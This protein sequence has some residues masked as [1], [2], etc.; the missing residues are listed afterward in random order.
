M[1]NKTIKRGWLACFTIFFLAAPTM[2]DAALAAPDTTS[3]AQNLFDQASFYLEFQYFGPSTANLKS[4]IQKYQ[5]ELEAACATTKDTCA[6][7]IAEP[8]LKTMFE[9]LEDG[10]AYYFPAQELQRYTQ[11]RATGESLTPKPALGLSSLEFRDDADVLQ[12]PDRLVIEVTAGSPAEKIGLQ[13]GDRWIG[14]N[15]VLFSSFGDEKTPDGKHAQFLKEFS[16]RVQA[17]EQVTMEI[18]RGKT[19]ERLSLSVR[20]EIFNS[21]RFPSLRML[22]GNVALIRHPDFSPL[23]NGGRFHGLVREAK[24]RNARAVILDMRRNGGGSALELWGV[25]GALISAPEPVRSVLRYNT[26]RDTTV[27]GWDTARTSVYVQ[28]ALGRKQSEQRIEGPALWDGA[29]SVLVDDGCASACEYLAS[30]IQRARRAN[31]IG[32][33]TAGVGNT[34]TRRFELVNGAAAS[35]P[36]VRSVWLDGSPLPATVTP[37]ILVANDLKD[38]FETGRDAML[39]R[40]LE[41]LGM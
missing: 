20:G 34:N 25:A 24:A 14:Y 2:T 27:S 18:V 23:G 9:S 21:A 26:D 8:I 41:T 40:A 15:G 31:V 7:E 36:T 19:R 16:K 10:H 30:L 17:L 5:T 32:T 39:E 12:S 13:F 3:P 11:V 29:L 6:Y 28:D 4:L 1:K 38:I 33:P 22:E 37:D 35:M